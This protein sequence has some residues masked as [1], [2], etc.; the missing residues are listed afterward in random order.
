MDLIQLKT[1]FVEIRPLQHLTRAQMDEVNQGYTSQSRYAVQKTESHE[2]TI[3]TAEL[4]DLDQPYRKRWYSDDEEMRRYQ[5][6]AALGYS[7]GA[8]NGQKLVGLA[9]S[10][11]RFWNKQLWVWEFHITPDYRGQGLGRRLMDSLSELAGQK[12]FRALV[13]ETQNYNVPAIQFY[14]KLGFEIDSIDLSYYTNT[15]MTSGE[16]AFFMKRKL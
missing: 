14:R 10:E 9:L 11:P 6:V 8:Y 3:I 15:D 7:L 5:D 13:C 4:E 16:V 1:T 2:R 12:G